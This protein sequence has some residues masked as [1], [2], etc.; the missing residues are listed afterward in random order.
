MAA[1]EARKPEFWFRQHYKLPA[2]DPRFLSMTVDDIVVEYEAH[3]AFSGE[4]LK[5]CPRCGFETHRTSCPYCTVEDKPMELTGD[6]LMDEAKAK[7]EEG[8]LD[9]QELEKAMRAGFE[10]V[11]PEE[12]QKDS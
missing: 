11:L 9:M 8:V 2:T 10:R 7:M 3:L 6:K 1:T 5:E 4:V 12:V